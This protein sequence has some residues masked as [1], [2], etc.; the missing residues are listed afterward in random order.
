M[1]TIICGKVWM[2]TSTHGFTDNDFLS[3][4]W[5]YF[6]LILY[7]LYMCNFQWLL[8]MTWILSRWPQRSGY[9]QWCYVTWLQQLEIFLTI[10]VYFMFGLNPQIVIIWTKSVNLLDPMMKCLASN[11]WVLS[12]LYTSW[13]MHGLG[14]TPISNG[15]GCKAHT[16]KGWGI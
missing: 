16:S 8:G 6:S 1:S 7:Y 15:Y 9:Q 4:K 10:S 5:L 3:V 14:G 13:Y 2:K 12:A 11:C